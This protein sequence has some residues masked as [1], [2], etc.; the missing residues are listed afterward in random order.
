[1]PPL[2]S[3]QHIRAE[4]NRYRRSQNGQ[5]WSV[6]T[7]PAFYYHGNFCMVIES[8]RDELG[9]VLDKESQSFIND[10]MNL[11]F[12]AQCAFARMSA[13]KSNIFN[14]EKFDYPEIENINVQ[15][16]TLSYA[17]FV[18]DIT[19]ADGKDFFTYL[20]KPELIGM[21]SENSSKAS[22]KKT[23]KKSTLIDFAMDTLDIA[24]LSVPPKFW[25][26]SRR[27]ELAYIFYLY[28]GR[29]DSP[30]QDL[31]LRDLGLV[32]Q[33]KSNKLFGDQFE[34]KDSAKSAFFYAKA[35]Q[36]LKQDNIDQ[37][38]GLIGTMS[39]W[40]EPNCPVSANQRNKLLYQLG[41]IS[42]QHTN[43]ETASLLY[44]E[45]E[46]ADCNERLIR[47]RYKQGDKVWVK[48]Y[49]E[50]TIDNPS[51]DDEYNFA[52]DF[53]VRKYNKKRTSAVTDILRDAEQIELDEAFKNRPEH[54]ALKFFRRKELTCLRTENKP[55]RTLFAL[56]FW[57]EIFGQ[58]QD[59]NATKTL[60]SNQFYSANTDSIER[61][62]GEIDTPNLIMIRLLKT[63]TANFG[64]KQRIIRWD[65]QALDSIRTLIETAP[66]GALAR[67]LRVMARNWKNTKDGFPDLMIVENGICRFVEIK[68]TG[69]VI[70]RNQLT[71]LQ[72]L[73]K[74][75]FAANVVKVNWTIDPNQ[76]YVV[77]DVE[78]T[79]GRPGL[80]RV[81]EIGAVKIKG[82]EIIGEWS[83]LINPQ[84][85][86]PPN[87]TRIT[88]ISH[89][90]VASAPI[91]AE[92]ADSF[93][94]FM[95]DAIFAAHNV[96]FDY[97]FIRAEY[98]MIDRQFRYSKICTCASM[99]RLYPGHR[100]YA[101]KN[102]CEAFNIE[103]HNHHRALCDAQAAAKLLLLV[104]AKRME[105]E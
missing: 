94:E 25:A 45:G 30:F 93:A 85:S 62:L 60:H 32:K 18:S 104:N 68:A 99:R 56:L 23:W 72:Q 2:V 86:I 19:P 40:P 89:D 78:T 31:T 17:H 43:I 11:P 27:D 70:R 103:L 7:L 53:Y 21:L 6:K 29:V 71:R 51:S 36:G 1:M 81:T 15:F 98:Q 73:C 91:F 16:E 42:E 64:V 34:C 97:G 10:F 28:S 61:K 4:R 105:V 65:T 41:K 39:D 80:H 69:D 67:M 63:F 22:F 100:S 102:L 90:M 12:E 46:S 44:A 83:S 88:G 33:P 47:L 26:Q 74:A 9:E 13:R 5:V 59:L 79:G 77:V 66:R 35:L 38:N 95:D 3:R 24:K 75:G 76:T 54:A 52:Q 57:D 58:T 20:T 55:W 8:V 87:I 92:I 14:V 84:R 101:L 96:N 82:G 49:L 50:K 37:N 48:K